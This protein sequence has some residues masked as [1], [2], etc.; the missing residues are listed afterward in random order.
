MELYVDSQGLSLADSRLSRWQAIQITQ[1]G[2]VSN[3]M[4]GFAVAVLGLWVSLLRDTTFQPQCAAKCL[5]L[6]SGI[7]ISL[8]IGSGIW[9]SLNRLW[10]FRITAGLAREKWEDEEKIAKQEE[11]EKLGERTWVLLYWQISTFALATVLLAA[12]LAISYFSKL[13]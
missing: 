1:L 7:S 13:F 12:T 5:F 2:F 3:L 10:D 6:L 8:S 4:L 11:S 9:C